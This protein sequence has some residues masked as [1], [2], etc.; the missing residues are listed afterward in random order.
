LLFIFLLG[1]LC[2]E[3]HRTQLARKSDCPPRWPRLFIWSYFVPQFFIGIAF[4]IHAV[5]FGV[6]LFWYCAALLWLLIP[7]ALQL[8]TMLHNQAE[9]PLDE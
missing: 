3:R 1:D 2:Y 7:A 5:F 8:L 4:A 9:T 6:S